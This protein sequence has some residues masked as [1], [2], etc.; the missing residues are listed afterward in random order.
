MSLRSFLIIA[1]LFISASLVCMG[2]EAQTYCLTPTAVPKPPAPPSPPP[3]C[4]PKECDKCTKSPCYVATGTYARDAVDLTIPTAGTFSLVASRLYDSS[5]VTDGPLGL[6]WSSSLTPRLYYATYLV[7]APSTY[8]HEAD[9][10]MPD[11]VLYRFTVDGSGAFSPPAGRYDKLVRNGD[12]TYSLTLGH[13]RSVYS[14]AA[15][16]SLASLT[17]DFGNAIT[18]T[19]DSAGRVQRVADSS[20]SGRYIDVTWGADGRVSTLTDNSGRQVKYYYDPT[21]GTLTGVADPSVSGNASLRSTNYAYGAGRFGKVLTTISDR[22]SRV[23]S[24]L[25]WYGDG[26]L[27]SYTDGAYDGSSTSAG[28]KYTYVYNPATA[29][30]T[31]SN[32][33]G[34]MSYQ[35]DDTG[36]VNPGNY[37]NGQSTTVTSPSGGQSQFQY[38][39]LGRVTT[40]T[41][42]SPEPSTSGNGTAVWWYTYDTIWPDQ[43]ASITPKDTAGNLKTNWAGWRYDYHAP[44]AAAPGALHR[45]W[46]VQSDTVTKDLFASYQYT[47]HGRLA[48]VTDQ[49]GIVTLYGYNA[50]SDLISITTSGAPSV[51]TF[52]Y[53]AL[54]RPLSVTDPNSHTTTRT[55]D[56]LDRTLSVTLPKPS[57]TSPYDT[58][59]TSS[60]DNYDPNIGLTF[61]NTTDANGHITKV[62]YD[63]LGHV[64]QTI[65]AAG[66]INQFIYQYDLLHKI[67]DA[68]GNETNYGYGPTR[69]LTTVTYP[70]GSTETYNAS[71]GTLFSRTNR[72]GK[73]I[74][75]VYDGIGRIAS[76]LYDGLYNNFGGRVGQFYAY[77]GQK[78]LELQDSQ[79]SA[80]MIHDYTYDSSWR[81]TVDNTIGGEKKTYAYFNTGSLVASYT[82]QP[83]SGTNTPTQSVSYGFG[84]NGQVTSETWSWLPS[85]PFTFDYTP[86]GRYNS[87]TFPNGQQ[88]RF[89]YD[90]QDRLASI[91]NIAP[92]AQTIASFAYAYD[93][94]W[95][96]SSYSMRGQR[97]SV[98]VTAP[99]A[100]NVAS[101]L[102][103]YSY[104]ALY[105]LTRA[106]YPDNTFEAWT[107]DA[108]GNRLSRRQ[109]NG[110]ILPYTY[111]TNASGGNTQRLRN[112][113]IFDFTYDVAGNVA[114]SSAFGASYGWDY[115]GRLTSYSGKTYAYDAF[116]RTLSETG[117]S[118]TRYISMDG[119]TVGERNSATGIVNDYIFGPGIDEPLAKRAANGSITY[120]GVDGLGSIVV[121]TDS[122]GSILSSSGYSPWGEAA[123]SPT[124]LFGYTGREAG[125]PSWYYRAR[126]YD[127]A[128]GRF[129]SE[130]PLFK[131]FHVYAYGLNDPLS[132][133]DP[134]GLYSTRNCNTPPFS[135][136]AVNGQLS[137]LCKQRL[138][139]ARC[140]R[141]MRNASRQATGDPDALPACMQ[142]LCS[143]NAVVTC[144]ASCPACG[145]NS[146]AE[147][148]VLGG[149]NSGCPGSPPNKDNNYQGGPNGGPV[150]AGETIFHESVH[151]CFTGAEPDMPGMS[152]AYFRYLEMECYG[153]RDPNAPGIGAP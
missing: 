125:G 153:W 135:Q 88:R 28:E 119:H 33:I 109:L 8:S 115:A 26:K 92:D 107:Y 69:N 56:S 45:V 6:G 20:G 113:G 61:T 10:E 16:G 146:I 52:T 4:Q 98:F 51:T 121:A 129:L 145:K 126:H 105:Q 140:Q 124:E 83:P 138:P 144:D 79:T 141:A 44:N 12:G 80:V 9:V 134:T 95:Q 90:N 48:G 151:T 13:T 14:F 117:G 21:D 110:W 34:S 104:D 139:S 102:T 32:S 41:K 17:D 5:R 78:L 99:N 73:T 82:I 133:T 40:V 112:D 22:W 103:K 60:Y 132:N 38:D 2:A 35:Y 49:N 55:Y 68:N 43:V 24:A 91:D 114:T 100:P 147:G 111:Y 128:R 77:D 65:D 1:C 36:L 101:G 37:V 74:R 18:W 71:G 137:V 136:S 70:D 143:G 39:T 25:E 81:P 127:A 87:I 106:D 130:D 50:A 76:A 7:T 66:N 19:Y 131:K 116:G 63:A 96:T 93:Y 59:V 97:T 67:R 54:G 62:G 23:I 89:T 46:R 75:Y 58:V 142:G 123:Y 72:L 108:V 42:P 47:S 27:K 118:T 15:D 85:A 86:T 64:A 31:K 29:T 3:I 148:I 84:A 149:G 30:T 53:D 152:A 57:A 11:G 122:I 150:G 120:F 94:D